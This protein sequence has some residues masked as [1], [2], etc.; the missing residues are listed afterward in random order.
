MNEGMN[1][2][3]LWIVTQDKQSLINVKEVTV[4]GKKI[5]GVIGSASLDHWGKILGKYE[6]NERALEILNEIFTK[7]EETSGIS[8]TFTMPNE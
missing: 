4:N 3:M 1:F 8:V 6:S 5:E 2:S 7:I